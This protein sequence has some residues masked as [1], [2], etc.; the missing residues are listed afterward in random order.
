[1]QITTR[2]LAKCEKNLGLASKNTNP[3][4]S[5]VRVYF[6][7]TDP[8]YIFGQ[9]FSDL[10]SENSELLAKLVWRVLKAYPHQCCKHNNEGFC[11]SHIGTCLEF[12]F[13]ICVC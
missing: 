6:P 1:V 3:L 4:T 11:S 8:F 5:L 2:Q 7:L 13:F 9:L 10:A 12:N